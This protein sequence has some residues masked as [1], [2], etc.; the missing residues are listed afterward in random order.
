MA[1]L[2]FF[3]VLEI[4]PAKAGSNKGDSGLSIPCQHLLSNLFVSSAT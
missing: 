1:F 3:P 4:K 2:F